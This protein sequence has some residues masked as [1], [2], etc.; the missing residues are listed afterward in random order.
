MISANIQVSDHDQPVTLKRLIDPN[1]MDFQIVIH[2]AGCSRPDSRETWVVMLDGVELCRHWVPLPA[3]RGPQPRPGGGKNGRL[4]LS[5]TLPRT[6]YGLK[7]PG[8]SAKKLAPEIFSN[9]SLMPLPQR[10]GQE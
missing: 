4:G 3:R 8:G 6:I 1:R 9:A 2:S 5:S 10:R 7:T